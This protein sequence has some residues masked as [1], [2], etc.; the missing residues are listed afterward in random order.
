MKL[1]GLAIFGLAITAFAQNQ[2]VTTTAQ[3]S[4]PAT[5]PKA[6]ESA[7]AKNPLENESKGPI[8]TEIYAD[9]AS[10]DSGKNMGIFTGHVKVFDPRF[11]LQSDKLTVYL[12][13]GE[14]QGLEK[15]IAEGNVGL[16]RDRP[17]PN[18]GPPTHA[19]GRSEHA[20]YMATDGSVELTGMPKVQQGPNMHIAP[21]SR[22]GN[23]PSSGFEVR[24]PKFRVGELSC[25][26]HD[27]KNATPSKASLWEAPHSQP[28]IQ[29][30]QRKKRECTMGRRVLVAEFMHETNTFSVQLT[31]EDAFHNS[32]FYLGQEIRTAFEGTRTSLGAAFEA[33][34]KFDWDVVH[35]L[36]TSANPSGRVTDACFETMSSRILDMCGGVDEI[37]LHLHGSMSTQS[38]DDGEGELLL[39]IRNRVGPH[40]PVVAVLDLHATVTQ[41]MA[42]NANAL[43]SYRTYPHIDQYERTWQAAELLEKAMAGEI[44]PRVALARR[45]ILYALD[46]GDAPL[47]WNCC[48]AAIKSRAQG[49]HSWSASRRGF[50]PRT[51]MTSVPRWR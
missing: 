49:K 22:P 36:A 41:A 2:V 20:V 11:N 30:S 31:D 35:P 29:G 45:P 17:D 1:L 23:E 5:S 47:S 19:V 15:A 13:K 50:P 14:D 10:F 44:T 28:G 39:R 48:V 40:V 38:H 16:V 42:D 18:G 25:L 37:L 9:E 26:C 12:R 46:G 51:F 4:K 27:Q 43:I 34:A 7:A 8:T 6:T 21:A 3:S 32:S 33:A 24:L